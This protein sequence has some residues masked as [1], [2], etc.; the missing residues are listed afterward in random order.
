MKKGFKRSTQTGLVPY[1]MALRM[2]KKDISD[3]CPYDRF[4]PLALSY[5][6]QCSNQCEDIHAKSGLGKHVDRRIYMIKT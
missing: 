1:H 4:H 2:R 5:V 3:P 6:Y